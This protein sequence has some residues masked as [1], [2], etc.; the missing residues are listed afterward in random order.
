MFD[1]FVEMILDFES[2]NLAAA[3]VVFRGDR[4]SRPGNDLQFKNAIVVAGAPAKIGFPDFK[5]FHFLV[6]FLLAY[7]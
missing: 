5:L 3:D 4:L 6:S 1:S 7:L 2:L